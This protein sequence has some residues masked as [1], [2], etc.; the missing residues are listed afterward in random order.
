VFAAGVVGPLIGWL[1]G[2]RPAVR[3]PLALATCSVSVVGWLVVVAALGDH[4]PKPVVTV[5]FVLTMLGGPASMVAF[6]VARDYNQARIVGT[7]SGAVNAGGFI[8]TAV[9]ALGFGWTLTLLG[10]ASPTT[11]RYALLVPIA[12]QLAGALRV[13]AWHRRVRATVMRW[14]HAGQE[15]PV[16]VERRYWWDLEDTPEPVVQR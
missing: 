16:R 1:I 5:L 10:G 11:M 14:Q 8:A 15:V 2:R 13:F 4:P 7:A 6:A 9:V 3:V 12:V